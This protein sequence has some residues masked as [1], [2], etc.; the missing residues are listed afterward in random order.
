VLLEGG[1]TRAIGPPDEVI[2]VYL[3]REHARVG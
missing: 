3:R 2:D 1:V